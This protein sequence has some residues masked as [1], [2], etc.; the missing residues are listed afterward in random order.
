VTG[1]IIESREESQ[2]FLNDL[3][4]TVADLV[5][6]NHYRAFAE[7]AQSVG[8]TIH[9]EAGGPHGAPI[10]ALQLLGMDSMPQTE[11]WAINDARPQDENRFFIKEAS[12]AAHVYG[13]TVVAAEGPTSIGP[14]WEERIWNNLRPTFDQALCEGLNL[15]FWHTFTS[16]PAKYGLPGEEYFAGTHFNPNVTWWKQSTGWT[17]YIDRSQFLMQ[18][19][20]PVTDVL[21]YYGDFVP[22][23]VRVKS[24]DPAKVLPGYDY[25]VIDQNALLQR[26]TVKDGNIV[27]PDGMTYRLL[28]L[29][30]TPLMSLRALQKIEELVAEGATILGPKPVHTTGIDTTNGELKRL[31]DKL[32][33]VQSCE[34]VSVR[35]RPYGHGRVICGKT[36]REVL[37]EERIKPDFEFISPDPKA[38]LDFVHRRTENADLYLIR[39]TSPD[40]FTAQV[41]LRVSHKQPELWFADSGKI[42]RPAVFDFS[43]DGR[44]QMPLAF[45]PYGSVVVVFQHS[46]QPHIVK[47]SRNGTLLFPLTKDLYITSL[48]PELPAVSWVNDAFRIESPQSGEFEATTADG[49]RVSA[50]FAGDAMRQEVKGP[51]QVKFT[52]GWGAPASVRFDSLISWPE[53]TNP[54][55]RYYSGTASYLTDIDVPEAWLLAGRRVEIDLG[56]VREFA[57]VTVNGRSLTTLW[58]PPFRLDITSAVHSGRNE[59]QVG[60]TNLWPNRLIG[61]EQP[62]VAHRFTHTNIRKFKKD[63]PLLPS[64]LLGPV[65]LICTETRSAEAQNLTNR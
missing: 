42:A 62:G 20:L 1:R 53:S 64:G 15:D 29:P 51:W 31:A 36:A 63:S 50:T 13:K 46:A 49:T 23:F 9:P 4:R 32:W 40:R 52:P 19:G 26:V 48:P 59:L 2:Y 54:G 22:N 38:N 30:A 25:D 58:E 27:L 35:E 55:I 37:T 65:H 3:R 21:Y 47:L 10:D 17:S 8:L 61:D 44:T 5:A 60:I 43:S 12:S 57:K 28:A 6:Q 41:M 11:F 34:G 56:E 7:H 14:Q 45:E 16:S 39:N 33:G 24:D 18:Q